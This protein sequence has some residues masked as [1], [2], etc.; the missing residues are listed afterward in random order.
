MN[1]MLDIAIPPAPRQISYDD[2][3][4]MMGSCF[5][6]QIGGKLLKLK[7]GLMQ[8][9]NGILFD[10]L[11]VCTALETYLETKQYNKSELVYLNELWQSWDHHSIFSGLNPEQV[12]DNI[13][14]AIIRAN[15]F[16]SQAQFLVITLG[17]SF[18]YQLTNNGQPVANCHRAPGQWFNKH[19]VLVEEMS[20]RFQ[21]L[22]ERIKL[23]NP[24]L[25]IIFT[26]SPVRH[27]RDGV[28]ENNRSKARLI[29]TVH[30][31][32]Q[33]NLSCH[34]F[35]AY[36]LVIDVLRDY[37]FFDVDL[38]HPNYPATAFVFEHFLKTW[39]KKEDLQ[40]AE[41]IRNIN[42]AFNHKPFQSET[43]AHKQFLGSYL[44]KIKE[45][46]IRH[47]HIDMSEEDRYFA[48][49]N[50]NSGTP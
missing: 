14:A 23:F 11:S 33:S 8:N 49:A 46:Q 44:R 42:N 41:E 10:P 30:Q 50:Q 17:S 19:L 13:N 4:M 47:P 16:L 31:L 34:Y 38:V 18:S 9:P 1:F 37:R 2:K 12:L 25:Q 39:V 28:V 27:I 45:F 26:I 36:E 40:I 24:D 29:E 48:L 3:I 32:V 7:F 6:E 43:Q 22:I 20:A 21:S 5:T 15:K 35:P